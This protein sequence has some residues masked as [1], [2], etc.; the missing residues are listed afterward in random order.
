[1]SAKRKAED[2]ADGDNGPEEVKKP[3]IT[4]AA[5][6]F[7]ASKPVK[8]AVDPSAF[9][10][11]GSTSKSASDESLQPVQANAAKKS[12]APKLD[13]D[14]PGTISPAQLKHDAKSNTN[15]RIKRRRDEDVGQATG[16]SQQDKKAST[17]HKCAS[18]IVIY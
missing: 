7:G 12:N 2:R 15:D 11:M 8:K 13:E 17:K 6:F 3:A 4:D 14:P 5:T 16:S 9:F 18:A 1:M 10:D